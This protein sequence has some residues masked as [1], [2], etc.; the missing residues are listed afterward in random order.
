MAADGCCCSLT[1]G[2]ICA[3]KELQHPSGC[4]EP[5]GTVTDC[6]LI[7]VQVIS[8][9]RTVV[10]KPAHPLPNLRIISLLKVHWKKTVSEFTPIGKSC[11][12]VISPRKINY[13]SINVQSETSVT[14]ESKTFVIRWLSFILSCV[15]W[16]QTSALLPYI[17]K[18]VK[19][20]E[21]VKCPIKQLG[22]GFIE[23]ILNGVKASVLWKPYP[24]STCG[25]SFQRIWS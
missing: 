7:Q 22:L 14:F 6:D 19:I 11:V 16:T 9:V 17:S 10:R 3:A 25:F 13:A 20:Q 1:S 24:K 18:P 12:I 15:K 8:T 4:K 5:C 21:P 2:N 23:K